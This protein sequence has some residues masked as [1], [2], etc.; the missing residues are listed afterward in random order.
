MSTVIN[1]IKHTL[2]GLVKNPGF[3]AVVVLTL[4]LGIGANTTVF[5]FVHAILLR[6]LPYPHPDRLVRIASVHTKIG[7]TDSRSSDLNIL[8]WQ[9]RS[10]VF[11]A[12]AAY[13]AW[14]DTVTFAGESEL[15][16]VN[17]AT[18]NLLAIL[19]IRPVHG[20]LLVEQDV[21]EAG[22]MLSHA[23][24][25]RHFG[26]DP[27]VI[28]Q[29]VEFEGQVSTVVGVLP[30]GAGVPAQGRPAPNQVFLASDLRR[31]SFP[32]GLQLRSVVGR[33]RQGATV[34]QA[35]AELDRIASDLAAEYPETNRD[36]GVKVTALKAWQTE[37]VRPA[38]LAVYVATIVILLIAC[39]NVSN[40]LL[41]RGAA[42]RKELAIRN[43]LGSSRGHLLTQLLGESLL[44]T[45]LGAAAGWLLARWSRSLLLSVAPDTL[46][47]GLG[48]AKE[49]TLWPATLI[50]TLLAALLSGLLPALRLSRSDISRALG[51][52]G[53]S[54]SSGPGRSRLLSG[55]VVGQV[56]I[57][58]ILL[59]AA[60]LML[61]SFQKI[62]QVD[63][64][65][66]RHNTLSFKLDP[67]LD[68]DTTQRVLSGLSAVP[69]V[70]AVGAANIEL[71]NDVF[72]NALEIT[73]WDGSVGTDLAASPVDYWRVTTDY[74]STAGIP[75][76]AGRLFTVHD[77]YAGSGDSKY[78]VNQ[79]L[80]RR[81]FP[82][83]SLI[84]KTLRLQW[85][86]KPLEIIGVVGA[87]K[88]RGLQGDDVPILYAHTK[89]ASKFLART[90][91]SPETLVPAIREAIHKVDPA[92][93]L[94][95]VTTTEEI[96]SRSLAERRFAMLLM[97]CLAAMGT[98]LAALG[99]YGVLSYAV[100]CRIQEIGIRVALGAPRGSVM[101]VTVGEGL[102]WVATGGGI[103]L[104]LSLVAAWILRSFL[105]GVS[106]FDPLTFGAVALLLATVA[107]FACWLPARRAARVDSMEALRCE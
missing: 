104:V 106:S 87:I 5:S 33:L 54:N 3:S 25:Q 86:K 51:D 35:Q 93:T 27:N 102:K 34:T 77:P 69:G 85:G 7:V 89:F 16:R 24:W 98:A 4:A 71:L 44:L 79:A 96:V 8:D 99:I 78:I 52:S 76:I 18:P 61:V 62:L 84:G 58:T 11:E 90:S 36:W 55:L 29:E 65:F 83:G 26:G 49:A 10:R 74:F 66:S 80:T 63:P 42:R 47:M 15:V 97:C 9:E 1:D 91:T 39:L 67:Q 50:V 37:L 23:L 19:G 46:A 12:I 68:G 107:L 31:P 88:H 57:S 103:G 14:D 59:V 21:E 40:L 56:T 32:R 43:A 22:I 45:L 41:I 92:L 72:S 60:G 53:R 81:L 2:R 48:V 6:P 94:S 95:R 17:W 70:Q 64:G 28:G 13:Q 82:K 38:L 105:F 75:L 100:S 101:R 30:P 20:R 73:L